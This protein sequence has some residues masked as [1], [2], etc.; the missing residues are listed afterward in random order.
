MHRVLTQVLRIT[1]I[2][3]DLKTQ[4]HGFDTCSFRACQA[5]PCLLILT[6]REF[7][8]RPRQ[9]RLHLCEAHAALWCKLRGLRLAD[10]PTIPFW[11]ARRPD[12]PTPY[13]PEELLPTLPVEPQAATN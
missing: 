3:P 4:R 11:D 2:P 5:D 8:G 1:D 6:Y 9:V 7:H 10:V 13:W 12:Q